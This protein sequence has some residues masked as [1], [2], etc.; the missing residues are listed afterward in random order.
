MPFTPFHAGPGAAIKA[1]MPRRF[2]LTV[3]CFVQVITDCETAYYIVRAEYPLHRWFHTYLGGTFVA[4]FCV[5]VGRPICNFLLRMWERLSA[6]LPNQKLPTIP[7]ISFQAA[8][9]GALLGS[10]THVLLDSIVHPDVSPFRPFTMNNPFY[11]IAS[12]SGVELLCVVAGL[13]GVLAIAFRLRKRDRIQTG[14]TS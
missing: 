6:R 13:L 10:Y 9:I 4:I 1:F 11:G 3:F 8:V 12:F 14:G 7:R 5:I 2:S